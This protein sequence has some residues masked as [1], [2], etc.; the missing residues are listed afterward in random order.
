MTMLR[1]L[2]AGLI[3]GMLMAAMPAGV[4]LAAGDI[5][6]GAIHWQDFAYAEM[7]KNSFDMA[8]EAVN[9]DGGVRGRKL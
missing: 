7:M 3:A 2:L 8:V 6:V 4:S 5:V 1:G 9:A